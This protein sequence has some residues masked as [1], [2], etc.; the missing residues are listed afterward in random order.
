MCHHLGYIRALQGSIN[1]TKELIQKSYTPALEQI[2]NL[3]S[4]AYC[5]LWHSAVSALIGEDYGALERVN[6]VLEIAEETDSPIICYLCYAAKGNALI[7]TNQFEA[8]KDILKK[9]LLC[10]EGTTHRRYLEAVYYNLVRVSLELGNWDEAD[11]YYHEAIPLVGLNPDRE[12]SR[13][14]YLKG[15]LLASGDPPDFGNARLLFEKSIQTDEASGAVVQAAQTKYYLAQMLVLKG[16]IERSRYILDEITDI[17]GNWGIPF[18][19]KKCD[20]ALDTINQGK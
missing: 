9:S 12:A 15:R 11:R 14:D 5:S 19:Q 17:F 3:Q 13:F 4:R 8:A 1:E 18:W 10:V 20:Q 7:A 16:E 2:S 6:K